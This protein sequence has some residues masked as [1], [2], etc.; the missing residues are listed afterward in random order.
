MKKLEIYGKIMTKSPAG[1]LPRN[2][3][4]LWAQRS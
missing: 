2:R 4:Q 1:W 3:D